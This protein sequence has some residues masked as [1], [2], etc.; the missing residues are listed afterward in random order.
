MTTPGQR[1]RV[2][3]VVELL[4][5]F[6]IHAPTTDER[7]LAHAEVDRGARL[8]I[9]VAPALDGARISIGHAAFRTWR[10][11]P[12]AEHQAREMIAQ[13]ES[14]GLV[15]LT[16]NARGML[17]HLLERAAR[18][19][20]HASIVTLVLDPIFVRENDYTILGVGMWADRRLRLRRRLAADAH[21]RGAVF[22]YR[23]TARGRAIRP[24]S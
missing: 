22:P 9:R 11:L 10:L 3:D 16:D 14:D 8:W 19:C 2:Q 1:L 20:E 6:E 18:L 23:P 15:A 17:V 12:L 4:R 21:D 24:S 13:L 5:R 7:F